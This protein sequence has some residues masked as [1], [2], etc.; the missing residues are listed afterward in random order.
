[1]GLNSTT[2][3]YFIRHAEPDFSEPDNYKRKL[4]VSGEIQAKIIRNI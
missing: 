4:T 1:M 3:L 2:I